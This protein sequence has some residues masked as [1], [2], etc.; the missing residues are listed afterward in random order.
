MT[1]PDTTASP[2]PHDASIAISD[3][4]PFCGLRV[5]ATPAT[6]ASTICWTATPIAGPVPSPR[7][8]RRVEPRAGSA[9]ARSVN[10][11]AQH[12]RT[13]ARTSAAPRTHRYVS[14]SPAKLASGASSPTADD[15]TATG[16]S[17][18]PHRRHSSA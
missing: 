2:K 16:T 14:C 1:S 18:V 8:R 9:I 11:L 4:S 6:S 15:R 17:A 13:A 7:V 10:R 5:K 12:R 3:R